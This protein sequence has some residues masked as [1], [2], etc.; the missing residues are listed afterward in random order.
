MFYLN[1][2]GA[3]DDP[4]GPL[5]I[6][7]TDAAGFGLL[8]QPFVAQ[9]LCS[10]GFSLEMLQKVNNEILLDQLSQGAGVDRPGDRLKII[11]FVR[12]APFADTES[13]GTGSF[14]A[15]AP[16]QELENTARGSFEES[17]SDK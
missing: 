10:A 16:Q 5:N 6:H 12:D 11:F 4:D 13:M 2:D 15:S 3:N 7:D 17:I 1:C 8:N 14:P 9:K